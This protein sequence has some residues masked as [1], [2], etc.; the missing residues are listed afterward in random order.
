MGLH[1][2]DDVFSRF[3]PATEKAAVRWTFWRRGRPPYYSPEK[4]VEWTAESRAVVGEREPVRL[5]LSSVKLSPSSFSRHKT[6][7][8]LNYVLAARE[9]YPDTALLPSIRKSGG[10]AQVASAA[11][12]NIFFVKNEREIVTPPLK[13]GCIAGVMREFIL[14]HAGEAEMSVEVAPV[15]YDE[16]FDFKG[17]FLTNAVVLFRPV[18]SIDGREFQERQNGLYA[19]LESLLVAHGRLSA[20][21]RSY[22]LK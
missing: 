21:E 14:R 19:K 5:R 13:T 1:I 20:D 11:G 22:L 6:L 10:A 18:V 15:K 3:V 8:A 9:T 16:I 17:A 2:P 12:Y 7:G 4:E